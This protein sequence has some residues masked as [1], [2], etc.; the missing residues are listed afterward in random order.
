[1]AGV[2]ANVASL[3]P[4]GGMMSSQR[5][6]SMLSKEGD[7]ELLSMQSGKGQSETEECLDA[8]YEAGGFGL[9]IEG[10]RGHGP[11]MWCNVSG[12]RKPFTDGFCVCSPGRWSPHLRQDRFDNGNLVF[13]HNLAQSLLKLLSSSVDVRGIAFALATGRVDDSPLSPELVLEGRLSDV[14]LAQPS[15]VQAACVSKNP[16]ATLLPSNH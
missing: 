13:H 11:P 5:G 2:L 3:S 14:G 7:E 4:V 6:F 9:Q 8:E 12:K 16:G 1:M 15:R 10:V